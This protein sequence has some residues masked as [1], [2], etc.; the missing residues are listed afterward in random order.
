MNNTKQSQ[1]AQTNNEGNSHTYPKPKLLS[2]SEITQLQESIK[3]SK[4]LIVFEDDDVPPEHPTSSSAQTTEIGEES[5]RFVMVVIYCMLAVSVGFHF[6]CVSAIGNN[7][8]KVYDV[9]N[10]QINLFNYIFMLVPII[11]FPLAAYIIDKVSIR[12]GV[13]SIN[14]DDFK[15]LD[16]PP[17]RRVQDFHQ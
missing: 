8:M 13:Y 3:H 15:R 6:V 12:L 7:F 2:N 14:I 10:F 1:D 11:V 17:R 5:Y 16:E 9:S 4:R